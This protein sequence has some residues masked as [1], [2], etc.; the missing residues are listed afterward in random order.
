[1]IWFEGKKKQII[2]EN[3]NWKNNEQNAKWTQNNKKN[4]NEKKKKC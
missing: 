2:E 1:M 4:L 3:K